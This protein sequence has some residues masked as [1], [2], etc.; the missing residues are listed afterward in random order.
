MRHKASD[1][2]VD[3]RTILD[4]LLQLQRQGTQPAMQHSHFE[5]WQ[6][7]MDEPASRDPGTSLE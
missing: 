1:R 7:Q 4:C 3:P 2:I 6:R 5:L